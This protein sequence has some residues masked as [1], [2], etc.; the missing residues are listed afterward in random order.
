[1]MLHLMSGFVDSVEKPEYSGHSKR[2]LKS[3]QGIFVVE[4]T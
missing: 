1:M 4:W 3:R 2:W